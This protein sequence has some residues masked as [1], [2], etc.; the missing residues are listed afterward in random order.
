MSEIERTKWAASARQVG[1][2]SSHVVKKNVR[3][4]MKMK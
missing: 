1:E 3:D 4:E 2:I